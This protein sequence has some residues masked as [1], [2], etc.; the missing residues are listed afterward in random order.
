MRDQF[1]AGLTSDTLR[2]KLI[3]KGHRHRNTA[4]LKVTLREVV[5]VAKTFANQLMKTARDTQPEQV[6][7]TSKWTFTNQRQNLI[8]ARQSIQCFWCGGN[9]QQPR[10]QHCPAFG[11]RFGKCGIPGHFARVCRGGARR[12]ARQQQLNFVQE[13]NGEE[14]FVADCEIPSQP[15]RKF[16]AHLHL[17]HGGKTKVV[18]AQ[19]NSASTCYTIPISLLSELF[20][21]VKISRTR[22]TINT[23]GSETIRPEGQVTLCCDRIIIIIII[24]LFI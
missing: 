12:Q 6:N 7:F 8:P 22:N 2:V 1:I 13:D 5:E 23:Y 15:A 4:Q 3:G 16:F 17:V 11:K 9:H 10:Q 21:D 24:T 20:P 18:K 14:A 19:I